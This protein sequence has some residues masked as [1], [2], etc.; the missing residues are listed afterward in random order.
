MP[1]EGRQLSYLWRSFERALP[2]P[3]RRRPWVRDAL[4][5]IALAPFL[6]GSIGFRFV[7]GDWPY[8]A[9]LGGFGFA[10]H[11]LMIGSGQMST[12]TRLSRQDL[13][14][15]TAAGVTATTVIAMATVVMSG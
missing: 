12:E 2:D 3:Q 6:G 1:M 9:L 10:M 4:I 7:N 8:A 14:R 11:S 5:A 13:L 15:I